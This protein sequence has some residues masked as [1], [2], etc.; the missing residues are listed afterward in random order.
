MK[1]I[2]LLCMVLSVVIAANA[3]V[4]NEGYQIGDVVEDFSLKNVDGNK[5]S[6]ADYSDA[7]GFILIFTCNTCPVAKGYE[8]RI[9]ALDKKYKA[10]GYPVIAINPNDAGVEPRE[11]FEQMQQRAKEKGFTF[12]YLLDPDHVV[13]KRFAATHTPHTF[14]LQKTSQG[15]VLQYIGAIDDDSRGGNPQ[16]KFVEDAIAALNGGSTP[17]PNMTKA[18]GCTI[19]WKKAS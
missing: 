13:T 7:K 11:S 18:I 19:K 6:L 8:D 16:T 4:F 14:L 3:P 17:N 12:P 9:I 2:S 5:V 1:T 10:Q 15:N